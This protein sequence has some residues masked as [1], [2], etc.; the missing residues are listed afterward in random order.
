[1]ILQAGSG[2]VVVTNS[3]NQTIDIASAFTHA[4]KNKKD[5][6][7]ILNRQIVQNYCK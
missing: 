6:Y 1:M 7:Q 4:N 3:Q 2:G 5:P